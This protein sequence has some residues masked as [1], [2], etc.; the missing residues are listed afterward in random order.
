MILIV[1]TMRMIII[2][3][4]RYHCHHCHYTG[5]MVPPFM[6]ASSAASTSD[7]SNTVAMMN[8][9][10]NTMMVTMVRRLREVQQKADLVWK[11]EFLLDDSYHK[12][13]DTDTNASLEDA[14]YT[15]PPM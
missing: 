7:S 15:L 3:L 2:I 8:A 6:E 1:I 9:M 12:N 4:Q 10:M 11:H 5:F 13:V 14:S